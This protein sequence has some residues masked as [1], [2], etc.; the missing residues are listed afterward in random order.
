[1]TVLPRNGGAL[2]LDDFMLPAKRCDRILKEL[3]FVLKWR[4][5][6]DYLNEDTMDLNEDVRNLY[7]PTCCHSRAVT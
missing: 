3:R 7:K 2:F 4:C 6:L 5:I 1:M